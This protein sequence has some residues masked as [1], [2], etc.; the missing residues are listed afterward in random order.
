MNA[1]LKCPITEQT[2]MRCFSFYTDVGTITARCAMISSSS[3]ISLACGKLIKDGSV[4][5][6]FE[7]QSIQ[8]VDLCGV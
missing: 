3:L 4:S 6:L 8:N 1:T 2:K 5:G 7:Y